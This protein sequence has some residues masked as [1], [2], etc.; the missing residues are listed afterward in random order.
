LVKPQPFIYAGGLL[1][2][3]GAIAATKVDEKNGGCI[4]KIIAE[5]SPKDKFIFL[6]CPKGTIVKAPWRSG[7]YNIAKQLQVPLLV[8]GLDYEKK[9]VIASESINYDRPEQEIKQ[10]LFDKLKDIVPLYPKEEV[11][12]IRK[13]NKNKLSIINYRRLLFLAMFITVL[14]TMSTIFV[15][16]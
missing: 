10:F 2:R 1:K 8:A 15:T 4:T 7:Y 12:A 9:T 3:L 13:Y 5:L 16:F 6:I 11:V 14:K